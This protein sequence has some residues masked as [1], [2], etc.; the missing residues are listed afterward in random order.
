MNGAFDSSARRWLDAAYGHPN[1]GFLE[2]SQFGNWNR[3]RL[4]YLTT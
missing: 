1:L 2:N 4:G 3:P